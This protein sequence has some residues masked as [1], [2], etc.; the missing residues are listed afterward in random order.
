LAATLGLPS[1]ES[2]GENVG[3]GCVATTRQV[4]VRRWSVGGVPLAGQDV[5]VDQIA[6]FGGTGQPQG[7]LGGDVLSRFGAVGINFKGD[8]ATVLHPE[9]NVPAAGTVIRGAP[10]SSPPS[11]VQGAAHRDVLLTVARFGGTA[12]VTAYAVFGRQGPFPFLVDSG[13]RTSA[14]SPSTATALQ[15]SAGKKRGVPS[16]IGCPTGSTVTSG[17]WSMAN[18]GDLKPRSM[19]TVALAGGTLSGVG[20]AL[21]ADF[22]SSYGSVVLDYQSAVLWLGAT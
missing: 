18:A 13:A 10:S 11:L 12:L 22:L 1:T 19:A 6:G 2:P 16:A 15:L 5:L 14:I 21:G 8:Q 4:E 3:I 7:I 9:G 20:G 17:P